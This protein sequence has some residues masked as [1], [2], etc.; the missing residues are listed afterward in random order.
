MAISYAKKTFTDTASSGNG[1]GASDLNKMETGISA[2]ISDVNAL[3]EYSDPIKSK[4][5]QNM[6][7]EGVAR[8]GVC[9]VHVYGEG[10]VTSDESNTVIGYL[11]PGFYPNILFRSLFGINGNAWG[12]LV[13]NTDGTIRL[14]QRYSHNTVTWVIVDVTATFV[15]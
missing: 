5:F 15:Y 11:K 12:I 9:T 6:V 4:V 3:H 1:L 14:T 2:V 10:V 13:I 7:V 8:A